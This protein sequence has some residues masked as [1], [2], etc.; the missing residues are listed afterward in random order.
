M[1]QAQ[2]QQAMNGCSAHRVQMDAG[3]ELGC[4]VGDIDD[5]ESAY[6]DPDRV[7]E[8]T[9][10]SCKGCRRRDASVVVLPCQHFCLCKECDSVAQICP[11]CY[12]YR[13]SSVEAFLC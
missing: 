7:L 3:N 11:I 10:P 6:I 9:G 2:L 1:L 13:S 5:A 12:S 4:A 8:L